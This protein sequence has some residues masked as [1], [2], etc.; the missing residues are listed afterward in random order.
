MP[1]A[2]LHKPA[3]AKKKK[4]NKVLNFCLSSFVNKLQNDVVKRKAVNKLIYLFTSF[5]KINA[6]N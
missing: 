1:V 2:F 3:K 4:K 6:S 5:T